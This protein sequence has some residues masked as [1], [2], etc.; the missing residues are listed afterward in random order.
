MSAVKFYGMATLS[1]A[2]YVLFDKLD[3]FFSDDSV[4]RVLL[5]ENNE[6]FNG[7]FSATQTADFVSKWSV[8]AHTPNTNTGYS[9][10]VFKSKSD[11][12]YVLAFRG[13][14][15]DS[16]ADLR[17]DGGIAGDGL[18]IWQIVDMYND[19]QRMRTA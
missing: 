8:T 14:E 18:A 1:E 2:S 17:T 15:P 19:I 5:E 9:S 3:G 7:E 13:T 11:N 10:T 6:E 12:G 16:L 4:K